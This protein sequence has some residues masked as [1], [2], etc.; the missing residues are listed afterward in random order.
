MPVAGSRAGLF[1]GSPHGFESDDG[2]G[3]FPPARWPA[4]FGASGFADVA[5]ETGRRNSA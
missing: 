3:G 4:V 2:F 1:P 5:A